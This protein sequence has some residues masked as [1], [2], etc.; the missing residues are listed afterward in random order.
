[1]VNVPV[2]RFL[3]AFAGPFA[4]SVLLLACS[5]SKSSKTTSRPPELW[6]DVKPVVSVKELMRDMID[7]ASD[8]IFDSVSTVTGPKGRVAKVPQ[9]DE[10]WNKVRIGAVMLAEGISLLKI[11]RPFTPLG[12][13]NDSAGPN[14][15]ELS[16]KQILAKL[17]ADPVLW[18]AKI[19]ALRNVGLEVLDIVKNKRFE[20]L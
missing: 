6:G 7:P 17:D 13:E 18:N 14:P 2:R 3:T 9:T 15:S 12:D 20:E 10:E 11:S 5:T 1:M 8:Y 4:L 16:P 19:E